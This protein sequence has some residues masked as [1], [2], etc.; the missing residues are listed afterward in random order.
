MPRVCLWVTVILFA[1]AGCAGEG[2][3]CE[4]L[5]TELCTQLAA[6]PELLE[7]GECSYLE[8]PSRRLGISCGVC[9]AHFAR[10]F[11]ADTTKDDAFFQRCLDAATQSQCISYEGDQALELPQ[12]C[13]G[14]LECGAG[15]CKG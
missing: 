15:P 14:L 12:A 5:A 13:R 9:E 10:A 2:T 4:R 6:C 8:P 1:L 11:C 3:P 7:P